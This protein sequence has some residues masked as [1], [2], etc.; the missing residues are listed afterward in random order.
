MI[1]DLAVLLLGLI[2]LIYL[3][4]PGAGNFEAIPDNIPY[5][6]NLY[7][8]AACALVLGAFRYFG[9]DLTAFLRKGL[10]QP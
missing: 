5:V 7:E 3:F 10:K 2:G 9:V 4:N 6:G 1:R 8:A